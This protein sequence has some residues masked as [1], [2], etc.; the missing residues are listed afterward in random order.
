MIVLTIVIASQYHNRSP[1]PQSHSPQLL[2]NW[3]SDIL[4]LPTLLTLL[5]QAL[6]WDPYFDIPFQHSIPLIPHIPVECAAVQ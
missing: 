3:S 2:I 4:F 5:L 6:F 1:L